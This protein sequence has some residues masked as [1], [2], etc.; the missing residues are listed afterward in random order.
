MKCPKCNKALKR[1]QGLGGRIFIGCSDIK[2][3]YKEEINGK[4]I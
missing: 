3:G 4:S 1:W 2:C